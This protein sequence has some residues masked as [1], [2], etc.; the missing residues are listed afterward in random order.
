MHSKTD[1]SVPPH[2]AE[3]ILAALKGE[4]KSITWI[5]RSGHVITRDIARQRVFDAATDFVRRVTG[6]RV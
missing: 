4:D 3:D 5:E 2:N 6:T 1:V